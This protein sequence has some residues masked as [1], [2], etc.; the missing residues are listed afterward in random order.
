M[1]R[2]HAIAFITLPDYF[3]YPNDAR[4]E[5]RWVEETFTRVM[6][7]NARLLGYLASRGMVH[8]AAIPL[9]HNRIQRSRRSDRGLYEW[10]RGGRLDRWLSSCRYPNFGLTGIL[11]SLAT[12][13]AEAG[14]SI[15]ALS[16]YD[17]DYVLVKGSD[18]EEAKR[19]LSAHGHRVAAWS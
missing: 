7:A 14:V 17:T 18:L 2:C 11:A 12:P 4:P 5:K 8:T 13:L 19:A 1:P 6:L 15:I 10:P 16:T 9:F 3:S